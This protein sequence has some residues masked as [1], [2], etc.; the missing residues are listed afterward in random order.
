MARR[1]SSP[2]VAETTSYPS[3]PRMR[4]KIIPTLGSSSTTRIRN[5]VDS[6]MV[7]SLSCGEGVR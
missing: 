7:S 2:V 1:H 3:S 6:F 5:S 4:W